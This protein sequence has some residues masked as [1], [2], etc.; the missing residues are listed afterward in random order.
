MRTSDVDIL[1]VPGWQGSGPRHWQSRWERNLR[2]A[3]RVVQQDWERPDKD[4]WVGTIIKAVAET[5]RPA[6][7]VAHSLGVIAVA[8]AAG[9]LPPGAVAGAF[10]VSAPDLDGT[11]SW[12]R[13]ERDAWPADGFGF[14]P[15]PMTAVPFPATLLASSDDPY[16]RIERARHFA[17]AWG[18]HLVEVGDAGHINET[19]GHGPWPEGVLRFGGFL[20]RLGP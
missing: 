16:C 15:V 6:V 8:H 7:L 3:R 10:L 17:A 4:A 13:A 14:P 5:N 9:K 20:G 1:I 19:S 12:P 18:A 2:T 11:G